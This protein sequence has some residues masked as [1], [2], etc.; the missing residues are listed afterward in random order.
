MRLLRAT[1]WCLRLY[2]L[3]WLV[4]GSW[5]VSNAVWGA[6][7]SWL[8]TAVTPRGRIRLSAAELGLD[9]AV[10]AGNLNRA[11]LH[12]SRLPRPRA[13]EPHVLVLDPARPH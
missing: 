4:V 5:S 2:A 6:L 13:P 10:L 11:L 9:L 7:L 3:W 1:L 8:V 12:A